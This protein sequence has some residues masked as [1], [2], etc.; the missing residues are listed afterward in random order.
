MFQQNNVPYRFVQV[1]GHVAVVTVHGNHPQTNLPIA[2]V[3]AF[4]VADKKLLWELR[5]VRGQPEPGRAPAGAGQPA[6]GGRRAAADLPGRV[7]HQGRAAWVVEATYTVVLTKDGLIAKDNARGT[8]LWTKT[9]VS[10]R[11]PTWSATG[12][13]SSC[14]T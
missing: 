2:K 10:T 1:K 11:G 8:V 7:V 13:S 14:T 12:S 6:D 4:D 9:N 5:P 3:Y